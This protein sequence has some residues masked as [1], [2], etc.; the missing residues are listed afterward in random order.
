VLT[1]IAKGHPINRIDELTPWRM[2]AA[3]HPQPQ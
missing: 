3:T 2:A 1:R